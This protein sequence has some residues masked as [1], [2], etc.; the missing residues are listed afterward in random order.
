VHLYLLLTRRSWWKHLASRIAARYQ[1]VSKAQPSTSSHSQSAD[2]ASPQ[3]RLKTI[4]DSN[5][6]ALHHYNP[7]P[8]PGSLLLFL[9]STPESFDLFYKYDATAGWQELC[10]GPVHV[11]RLPGTHLSIFDSQHTQTI[12]DKLRPFLLRQPSP[13]NN[14]NSI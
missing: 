8:Y 6:A 14:T 4:Q 5:T 10:D 11:I 2:A 7:G 1:K 12:A 13:G 3:S 9:A